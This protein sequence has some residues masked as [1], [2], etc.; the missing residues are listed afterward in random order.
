MSNSDPQG[1]E[2][3]EQAELLT[4]DASISDEDRREILEDIEEVVNKNRIHISEDLFRIRPLKHGFLLPTFI[5]VLAILSVGAGFFFSARFF[6][7]R[8]ETMN[9]E[10]NAIASTEGRLIEELK[11]ESAARIAQ[12]EDEINRIQGELARIETQSRSLQQDFATRLQQ[13]EA[14][15]RRELEAE[16][17]TEKARLQSLGINATEVEN[18]LRSFELQKQQELQSKLEEFRSQ[19]TAEVRARE[20][21]LEQAREI[22]QAILSEANSEREKILDQVQAREAEIAQRFET[23]RQALEEASSEAQQ[24]LEEITRRQENENLLTDQI[25]ASYKTIIDRMETGEYAAALSGIASLRGLLDDPRIEQLP[26]I[27]KRR[28]VERF[29]LANLEDEIELE[30]SGETEDTTGLV[31]AA[32]R[33]F[34]ART[35]VAQ[36]EIALSDGNTEQARELFQSAVAAVPAIEKA[37]VRLEEYSREEVRARLAAENASVIAEL[38]EEYEEEIAALE[39]DKSA[40]DG[41]LA[42]RLSGALALA[43]EYQADLAEKEGEIAA[44][45][46]MIEEGRALLD[47]YE[48]RTRE[49]EEALAA[50]PIPVPV[51]TPSPVVSPGPDPEVITELNGRITAQENTIGEL[52]TQ[53]ESARTELSTAERRLARE[54]EERKQLEAD[55]NAAVLELVDVVTVREGDERYASLAQNYASYRDRLQGLIGS[56]NAEYDRAEEL[57]TRF[58]NEDEVRDLFPDLGRFT[59][60]IAASRIDRAATEAGLLG[61]E[62]AYAS[63]EQYARLLQGGEYRTAEEIV[64][65]AAGN[66]AYLK[67]LERIRSLARKN[68]PAVATAREIR[69][70][71]TIAGVRGDSIT[72]ESLSGSIPA[73]GSLFSVR[74]RTADGT[75]ELVAEG[76]IIGTDGTVL[77]GEITQRLAGEPRLVDLV[78]YNLE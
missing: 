45:E 54:V 63:V 70:L 65:A 32:Q 5:N 51:P 31:A 13:K 28:D 38:R 36:G 33:L 35:L 62:T 43:E 11:R 1:F 47:E 53:I 64:D 46:G 42:V 18:R 68:D 6:E 73:E 10:V 27:A 19:A 41:E 52:S 74:R 26:R 49:A 25:I 34:N 66:E 59:K 58:Y 56:D 77:R 50:R 14:E 55:L 72:V 21:E 30:R 75:E 3:E 67:A 20:A 17:A 60:S 76:R 78:Y 22:A 44:L 37:V 57:L 61:R 2:S 23:E 24:R 8:Q 39:A 16:L 15:L 12:K 69:F 40:G 48:A 9:L 4:E 7:A 29:I 71:G